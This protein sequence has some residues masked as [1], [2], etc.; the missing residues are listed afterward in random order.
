MTVFF[1]GSDGR[2]YYQ[3]RSAARVW[4]S[5]WQVA[6]AALAFRG[7]GAWVDTYDYSA[8]SPATAAADLQAHGVRTLYLGTARYD[9][10]TDIL[11]PNGIAAWLAA[12]MPP[13]SGWS[14]GMSPI[15]PT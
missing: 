13:A 7:L 12:D 1:C 8:L 5:G 6:D 15:T 11:Y 9:S 3:Q 4:S 14:A 10:A 2:Y